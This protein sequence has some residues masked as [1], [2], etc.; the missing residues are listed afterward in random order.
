MKTKRPR[1]QV[2]WL[3][4]PVNGL[5]PNSNIYIYI[6]IFYIYIHTY[7]HINKLNPIITGVTRTP[8]PAEGVQKCF[9]HLTS[10]SNIQW[11]WNLVSMIPTSIEVDLQIVVVIS[12]YIFCWC[13][14]NVTP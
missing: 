13:Q 12:D 4:K 14:E 10:V 2:L 8:I 5:N 6:Y 3:L 7:L 1:N 11:S 9:A